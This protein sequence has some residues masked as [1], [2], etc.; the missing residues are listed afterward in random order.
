MSTAAHL[1]AQV[2]AVGAKLKVKDGKLVATGTRLP[3]HLVEQLLTH[4]SEILALLSVPMN[5]SEVVDE[6]RCRYCGGRM[7]DLR[8]KPPA[9]T[10]PQAW[11]DAAAAAP[12]AL[13]FGDRSVAHLTCKAAA[14]RR[15]ENALPAA[16]FADLS[17]LERQ[18]L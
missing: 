9:A 12:G 17:S 16:A 7:P 6:T 10:S 5:G 15:A 1:F 11:R 3:A 14:V 18:R 2:A 13:I 4:K 8:I